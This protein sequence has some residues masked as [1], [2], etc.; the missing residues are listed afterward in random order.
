MPDNPKTAELR[1]P[2]RRWFQFRLR[3]LL[4]SMAVMAML[5]P[6]AVRHLRNWERRRRDERWKRALDEMVVAQWRSGEG[7]SPLPISDESAKSLAEWEEYVTKRQPT[8]AENAGTI[9]VHRN[10]RAFHRP[11]Q[12]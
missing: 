10:R 1:K 7:L 12:L 11:P 8:N 4:I 3:T 9:A 2:R 5:C 6:L